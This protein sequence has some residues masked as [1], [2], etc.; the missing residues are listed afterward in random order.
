MLLRDS[1]CCPGV[2][3]TSPPLH[4]ASWPR[5]LQCRTLMCA[6]FA[7]TARHRRLQRRTL[8]CACFV[9]TAPAVQVYCYVTAPAPCLVALALAASHSLVRCHS[10]QP[11]IPVRASTVKDDDRLVPS[12]R[13]R[14]CDHPPL[15]AVKC[16]CSSPPR[17][18][19]QPVSRAWRCADG[20][21][22]TR[23]HRR[24]LLCGWVGIVRRASVFRRM[25]SRC[26]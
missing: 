21:A 26:G 2:A 17:S 23:R 12:T 9:V 20:R 22:V 25:H 16:C 19:L 5:R 7:V 11:D 13:S 4:R 15:A 24:A 10:A 3:A 18:P 6:C 1:A 14:P 8:L